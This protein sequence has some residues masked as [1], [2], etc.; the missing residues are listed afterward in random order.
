MAELSEEALFEDDDYT[1]E[2]VEHLIEN[3][4]NWKYKVEEIICTVSNFKYIV[5]S[6]NYSQYNR[7]FNVNEELGQIIN[8]DEECST[9]EQLEESELDIDLLYLN[10][11]SDQ[12]EPDCM[13]TCINYYSVNN[14][15]IKGDILSIVDKDLQ[16]EVNLIIQHCVIL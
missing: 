15:L 14:F 3:S 5:I 8:L 11:E 7:Q 12:E 13:F 4:K 6:Y 10:D 1:V 2:L 9:E 16:Q